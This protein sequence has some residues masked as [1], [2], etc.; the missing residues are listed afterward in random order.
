MVRVAPLDI[1][2]ER[3]IQTLTVLIWVFTQVICIGFS[4][5]M[6]FSPFMLFMLGYFAWIFY[7]KA[8]KFGGRPSNWFKNLT[9]WKHFANFFPCK[10]H[11]SC[12]LDPNQ[13]YV[14]GYHPHGII[15]M[16]GFINFATNVSLRELCGALVVVVPLFFNKQQTFLVL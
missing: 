4:I 11:K 9:W 2:F 14:F 13:T 12:D 3:R 16:G 5:V 6:F 15:A 7:D 10:L 1:P 8:P